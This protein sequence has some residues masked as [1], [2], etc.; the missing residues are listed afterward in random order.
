MTNKAYKNKRL[1]KALNTFRNES[2]LPDVVVK[3]WKC[4]KCD[5]TFTSLGIF[6]RLC[7]FCTRNNKNEDTAESYAVGKN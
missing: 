7:E 6:N 5:E 1:L 2:G 4:L 3:K